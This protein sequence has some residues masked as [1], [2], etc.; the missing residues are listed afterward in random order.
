MA[1]LFNEIVN[2]VTAHVAQSN[3]ADLAGQWCSRG[4]QTCHNNVVHLTG[5]EARS[6]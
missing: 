2:H 5:L 3:E 6:G 1:Y 4:H